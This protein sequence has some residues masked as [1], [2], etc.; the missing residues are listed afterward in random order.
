VTFVV[1]CLLYFVKSDD[2][3]DIGMMTTMPATAC[4]FSLCATGRFK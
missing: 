4:G 1:A 2:V 3:F